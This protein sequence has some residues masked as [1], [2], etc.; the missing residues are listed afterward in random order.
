MKR[1]KCF[2]DSWRGDNYAESERRAAVMTITEMI[3]WGVMILLVISSILEAADYWLEEK[4]S[5]MI[6]EWWNR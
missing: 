1:G 3:A 4:I 2:A 6:K 5:D